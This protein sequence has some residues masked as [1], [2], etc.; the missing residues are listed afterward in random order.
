M[1]STQDG[2]KLI[3]VGTGSSTGCPKPICSLLFPPSTLKPLNLPR[4]YHH[5]TSLDAVAITHGHADAMLG[6]DDIWGFQRMP[7]MTASDGKSNANEESM[8]VFMSSECFADIKSSIILNI[9]SGG[10]KDGTTSS[11]AW[12]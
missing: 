6:L 5:I 2:A 7:Y 12:K 11:L 3:F 9:C 10:V 8:P 4:G 1:L